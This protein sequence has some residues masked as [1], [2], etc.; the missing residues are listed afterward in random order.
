MGSGDITSWQID[1]ETVEKV[2]DF[3]FLGSKITADADCSPEIKRHLF[4]G[5]KV[6]INLD[7]I[8]RSRGII[9]PTKICLFS[10]SNV[11]TW[12]AEYKESWVLKNWCF[13]IV[14]LEKTFE[15]SLDYM[16]I[17]PVHPKGNQSWIFIGRTDSEAETPILWPPHAKNWLIVKT[18][19]L[20]KI[21]SRRR[22]G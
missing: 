4:L 8:L 6:M 22:K 14:V 18:L 2:T 21:E 12:E 17:Q 3:I 7:S 1:G 20:G 5:R 19:M 10:S 11:W 13:W 15:S 16:E 9:L